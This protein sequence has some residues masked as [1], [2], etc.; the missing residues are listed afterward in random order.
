MNIEKLKIAEEL[1]FE[2]YPEGFR[3]PEIIAIAKKHKIDKMTQLAQE[4]FSEENFNNP[5]L[6]IENMGKIVSR[7]SMV[8]MFEKPKFR[9][10]AK[11]LGSDEKEALAFGLKE[12]LYGN[13][14]EGFDIVV[15]ILKTEKLAKWPLV[16]ISLIY[17]RPQSEVFIKPTTVKGIIE[18][19]ELS[20]LTY[21]PGPTWAF[22]S[23][24]RKIFN[25]MK[26]QVS[27][28]LSPDNAAF[29]GFLMMSL[30]TK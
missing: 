18:F 13:E 30:P 2:R 28:L 11:S 5:E 17:F 16:T 25:S 10:F 27:P 15:D 1:F 26:E 4:S 22:Y 3:N 19:L 29:S 6:I 21:K 7:A 20:S 8:S 24:Y 23:E 9:D 12:Q 14:E